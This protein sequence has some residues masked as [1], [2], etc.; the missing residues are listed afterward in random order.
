MNSLR[1]KMIDWILIII[2]TFKKYLN[3]VNI[4]FNNS[5]D[6]HARRENCIPNL[7]FDRIG[8][9][10]FYTLLVQ[11]YSRIQSLTIVLPSINSYHLYFCFIHF[12]LI[13]HLQVLQQLAYGHGQIYNIFICIMYNPYILACCSSSVDIYYSKPTVKTSIAACLRTRGLRDRGSPWGT[14]GIYVDSSRQVKKKKTKFL[15][16][17]WKIKNNQLR[18]KPRTHGGKYSR[19]ECTQIKH[20][21][22][23]GWW[24]IR[25]Q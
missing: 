22:W 6:K 1:I 25:A 2:Y 9:V 10:L 20:M 11:N 23:W 14:T 17:F 12:C 8:L 19:S 3:I 13:I 16:V 21:L 7:N 5:N 15:N 18:T 24:L 4:D